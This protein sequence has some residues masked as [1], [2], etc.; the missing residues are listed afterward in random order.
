MPSLKDNRIVVA[1]LFLP[2]GTVY[3]DDDLSAPAVEV[4]VT[5]EPSSI[6]STIVAPISAAVAKLRSGTTGFSI[7]DDL[8]KVS[9]TLGGKLV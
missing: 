6:A 7:V 3:Y 4:T 5:E 8:T 1:S 9:L 2:K